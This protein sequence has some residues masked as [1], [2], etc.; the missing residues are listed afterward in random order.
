MNGSQHRTEGEREK[1][2]KKEDIN[3]SSMALSFDERKEGI[4]IE[5]YLFI[6][7]H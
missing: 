4:Y 5:R 6:Y 7:C 2:K 3:V 1:K